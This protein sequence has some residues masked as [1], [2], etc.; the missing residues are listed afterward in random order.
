MSEDSLLPL[1]M[2]LSIADVAEWYDRLGKLAENQSALTLDG[3]SVMRVDTAGLQLLAVLFKDGQ[4]FPDGVRW[5]AVSDV[6][7]RSAR[8]LGLTELL[9]IPDNT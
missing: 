3:A 2:E 6:L 1:P 4:S 8:I 5:H 7:S 9:Q